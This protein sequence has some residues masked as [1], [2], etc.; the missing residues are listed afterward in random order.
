MRET[1]LYTA[2]LLIFYTYVAFPFVVLLRG[3]IWR[4]PF[5]KA[6]ITP[7]VS[8][9]IVAHNEAASLRQKL[10]NVLALDYPAHRLETIVASDGSDDG[11]DDIV[12]RY[13][14][15]GVKLLAFPRG[16][17]IRALNAAVAQA[18]GEVI[19]FSDANSMYARDALRHL[20]RP[21]ADPTVGAVAGNQCYTTSAG[22][23]A[24]F[25]ERLYWSWDRMLKSMQNRS[26]S[27]I[28]ATGAIHAVRRELFQPVPPGVGDDF[29]IST[30]AIAQGYRLAFEP[31][32]IAYEPTAPSD[33][34]EF[35]RKVR[36]IVRGLSGLWAVK[37]LFNPLRYGFYSVQIFSHKLLRWSIAWLLVLLV[38]TSLS[39][40][41]HGAFY[42]VLTAA[43]IGFYGCALAVFV[44]GR[45]PLP[46]P[47]RPLL[48]PYYFCL[49]NLAALTAW[50]RMLRGARLDVWDP[51]R[52]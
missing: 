22:N 1:I 10:D 9:V 20:V 40:Y 24:S 36:V 15:R 42:R 45:M 6:E 3:L 52:R 48:I 25:G 11:T 28:S 29:V 46:R 31:E 41:H 43:Q 14:G 49:A 4:R 38:I 17:K 33:G 47:L 23:A 34:A 39:L 12:I 50:V 30:R 51:M 13:A 18:T 19:A 8:L 2:L 21:F 27:V 26:G 32:A 35:Q 5:R 44:L 7:S 37:E 16:G